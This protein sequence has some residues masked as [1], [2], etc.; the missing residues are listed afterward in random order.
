MNTSLTT[1]LR[2]NTSVSAARLDSWLADRWRIPAPSRQN[3][4]LRKGLA[5]IASAGRPRLTA[6]AEKLRV[7]EQPFDSHLLALSPLYRRARQAF[8]EAGGAFRSAMVSS[9]RSLSSPT[10]LDAAVDYSPVESEYLW[11]ATDP[12]EKSNLD[13]LFAVRGYVTSLFHEQ[14]HRTLWSMLPPAPRDEPGIRR[15]L[16]LAESL[17]IAMDMALG[18]ELGPQLANLFYVTGATYDPGTPIRA[19]LRSRRAYRNYLQATA[20]A[21]YLN[22]ELYEPEDVARVIEALFPTLGS[23]R[24]RA[25]KRASNLDRAFVWKTNPSWQKKHGARVVKARSRKGDAGLRLPERPL[26]NREYYLLGEH[27][28]AAFGL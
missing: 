18:D 20:Y 16:N 7:F 4:A 15:Y 10:L 11:S 1:P 27:W 3:S 19:E 2:L 8:F 22:L 14:N 21:T 5:L 25:A 12:K 24:E 17:V 6:K 26:D 9:P 28:F 23:Y 13:H